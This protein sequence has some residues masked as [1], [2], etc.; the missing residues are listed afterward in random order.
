MTKKFND[1]PLWYKDGIMYQ[2]HIKSFKDS[3]NDGIGDFNGLIEKLDYILDLGVNIVWLLPFYPSPM[4][5][6]GYDISDYFDINPDYGVIS[7]FKRFLKEAHNRGIRVLTELVLN[8]TSDQHELFQKARRSLPASPQRNFYVWADTADKYLDAR[9]IFSDFEPSNWR[10]DPLAK[11]YYWHRFYSHQPDLNFDNPEVHKFLFKAVDFWFDMGVDGLR[12]D[13][14]P[15]LYEREGTSCENLPE[16]HEFLKK[17]SKHVKERYKN[18]MLLAEANQW[19]EDAAA[20]FGSGDECQMAFHFPL[21]PRMYMAVQ[22]ETRFPIIDIIEQTPSIPENCQWAIFLR[23]HDE[24]TLEMVTDEE[25]DYMYRFFAKD[26][27]A[28]IN[29]GIRRRLAPLVENDRR[30][31]ELLNI[32]LFSFPGTPTIYYGDEIGM[33]DN[34]YLGDRN[35]VRTPMQWNSDRNAGFS[36]VNPQKLFLPIII[37]PE[38]HYEA[39][40]VEVQQRN[41]SSLLLW[42]KKTLAIRKKYK[43]F[44]RGDIEFLSPE[45]SKVLAFI[46]CYENEKILVVANLSKTSQVVELDLSKYKGSI[47]IEI[48]SRNEFPA[49]GELYYMLTL[50]AYDFYWFFLSEKESIIPS[51]KRDIFN[52]SVDK[53]WNGFFEGNNKELFEEKIIPGYFKKFYLFN[54]SKIQ[55]TKIF[56]I[57]DFI[58]GKLYLLFIKIE[59]VDRPDEIYFI[60]S[61]ITTEHIDES[62]QESR[63]L[64]AKINLNNN[65]KDDL[66]LVNSIYNEGLRNE[67]IKVLANKK[68]FNGKKG[69]F[70]ISLFNKIRKIVNEPERVYS[71]R[72]QVEDNY[73]ISILADDNY[74]FK[75]YKKLEEGGTPDEEILKFLHKKTRFKNILPLS[76]DFKYSQT[77]SDS[78]MLGI[79]NESIRNEGDAWNY[80]SDAF[81]NYYE[82][83]S[84]R[85]DVAKNSILTSLFEENFDLSSF[86]EYFENIYTEMAALLGKRTAELHIA[87]SSSKDDNAFKPEPVTIYYQRAI[88]QS[89]RFLV[90]NTFR[91]LNH[92]RRV[93]PLIKKNEPLVTK[94]LNEEQ[95]LLEF[96]GRILKISVSAKK[97]RIHGNYNLKQI[98]FSGKDFVITNFEGQY[99]TPISDRRLKRFPLRDIAS[100]IWSLHTLVYNK[101]AAQNVFESA[102][103]DKVEAS[104][105]QWWLAVSSIIFSNYLKIFD[106]RKEYQILPVEK[107]KLHYFMLVYLFEKVLTDLAFGLNLS[108]EWSIIKLKG[109]N[110]LFEHIIPFK[111][112]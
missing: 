79:I 38:Y 5:D 8:H 30:K 22:M 83:I 47:P 10:W 67:L 70:R 53:K 88:Y 52:L 104:A 76:G 4:K 18:K 85:K 43:A 97:I 16:T 68:I 44:G 63:E 101:L 12:L 100:L 17:L 109:L 74:I 42:M 39:F 78:L 3:N 15:Y 91:S 81:N 112:E 1:D 60:F 86:G 7:D 80:F 90:K 45:N 61:G 11:A 92:A 99:A 73:T 75:F 108:A 71:T 65:K 48:F 66:Y 14:V 84:V 94:I 29:L 28:R 51:V 57:I 58:P 35:G 25:R 49:I 40:N 19:P 20:Y 89:M 34:Y 27:K 6:D 93:S 26:K 32:L 77:G 106:S 21:M 50:T 23:N 13:A 98:L 105:Y 102:S 62:N 110:Q 96:I 64:I 33:G 31:I 82:N 41:P 56:D 87:L 69:E 9:I 95:I 54:R 103:G 24:L 2:V 36:N 55:S 46:R 59:Y 72:I 37:D 111:T 107:D